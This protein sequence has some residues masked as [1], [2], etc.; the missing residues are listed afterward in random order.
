M[1][2][3]VVKFQLHRVGVMLIIAG[4]LIF[5][6][7]VFFAGA[8]VGSRASQATLARPALPS[9]AAPAFPPPAIAKPPVPPISTA[10][11]PVAAMTSSA[12]PQQ[13]FALRVGAFAT[14]EEA[15]ASVAELATRQLQARI[16]PLPT[17]GSTI[18][19][20]VCVGHYTTRDAAVTMAAALAKDHGLDASVVPA[21]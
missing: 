6:A 7:L 8:L 14:E 10:S 15:K 17:S 9:I 16:V 12:E 21:P 13:A 4:A 18:L 19:Y 2:S 20:T 3:P 1:S 11:M 5:S